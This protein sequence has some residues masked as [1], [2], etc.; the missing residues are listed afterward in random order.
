M[1]MLY[2][3]LFLYYKNKLHSGPCGAEID[4][5]W[6]ARR[7]QRG[8]HFFC[9]GEVRTDKWR[10]IFFEVRT[11]GRRFYE[12]VRLNCED[13]ELGFGRLDHYIWVSCERNKMEII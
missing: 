6:E 3:K 7:Y 10:S 4:Y 9:V 2:C 12:R 5:T 1:M 8:L 13:L 11:D